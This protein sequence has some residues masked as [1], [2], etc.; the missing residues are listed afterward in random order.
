MKRSKSLLASTIVF[1]AVAVTGCLDTGGTR[2]QKGNG[3]TSVVASIEGITEED[4]KREGMKYWLACDGDVRVQGTPKA[5][6]TAVEFPS[7]NIKNDMVCSMEIG[8]SA[9][10]GKKLDWEWFGRLN[11]KPVVGLMYGSSKDKVVNKALQL[12][13]Y[14][15][16]SP[17]SGLSFKADL[18]VSFEVADVAQM[19]AEDKVIASLVCGEKESFAGSYKKEADK[20][21][22]LSFSNLKVKDLKGRSCKKVAILVDNKEAFVGDTDVA[23]E[24]TLST[25]PLTFP[26]DETK[27]YLLKAS[28]VAGPMNVGIIPSG[29]CSNLELST[30]EC[31][32]VRVVELPAYTKHYIV[33]KVTGLTADGLGERI[34]L[35]V[36][37][38][39]GFGLYEGSKLDVEAVNKAA[40]SPAG[41][42]ERKVFSFYRAKAQDN[43]YKAAFDADFIAGKEFA[44]DLA[45][46][47][48]LNKIM[49]VHIEDL[50]VHGMH[51]VTAEDLN[52]LDSAYWLALVTA[53][54]DAETKE[55]IATG[56]DKYFHSAS[57]PATLDGKP[58][59]LN[60][61][62]L[63]ADMAAATGPAKYRAY[64]VS[65]GIMA[66]TGCKLE[67][68]AYFAGL[69]ERHMGNLKPESGVDADFDSCSIS[70]DKFTAGVGKG[71]TFESKLFR[72]GWH[73]LTK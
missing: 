73:S 59:F 27:R 70:G 2:G 25:D 1:G 30:N 10:E 44:A 17:K 7:E 28:E 40:R 18:R 53:K 39:P 72:F 12:K 6:R 60:T 56:F 68:S 47:E 61:A 54:K 67:K 9:E 43:V 63:V 57:A 11:G 22:L 42:A 19:P 58:A 26:K 48:D 32:D 69:S 8:I 23:F 41:S 31:K 21:A 16:Y 65:G 4:L 52:K 51:S 5:D 13:L 24:D 15:I 50:R 55:F 64:A 36:G 35:I 3:S 49:L 66:E 29:I 20:H 38:G 71:Y 33:A 37:A 34:T 45:T 14:R 46:E 62:T